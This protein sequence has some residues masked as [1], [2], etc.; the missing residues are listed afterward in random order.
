MISPYSTLLMPGAAVALQVGAEEAQPAHLRDQLARESARRDSSREWPAARV[1]HELARRLPHQQLLLVEQGIDT[2]VVHSTKRHIIKPI[3]PCFRR[4]FT[5]TSLP[6]ALA[7]LLAE[8]RRAGARIL[9]LTESNPTRAGLAYPRRDRGGAGR[10][11]RAGLRSA[12]GRV[13]RGARSRLPLLRA[14]GLHRRAGSRSADRQHQRSVRLP[15]QAAGRSRR[16]SAG[17]A[18]VLS[19]VRVSGDHGIAARRAISAGL[20]RRLVDR[21]RGPGRGASPPARAPSCW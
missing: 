17:A 15:L 1:L 5:G 2:E 13:A 20:S 21:F 9:D 19:A 8:K 12:A 11:A 6:T 18:A 7:R 10:P 14:G 3:I 4:D 16:R